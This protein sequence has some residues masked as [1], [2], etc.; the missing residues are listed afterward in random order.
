[1]L[2]KNSFTHD[3]R[4]LREATSLTEAGYSVTVIALMAK[5]LP[6]FETTPTAINIVRVNRGVGSSL[7]A[8]SD[9]SQTQ[10]RKPARNRRLRNLA[11]RLVKLA[12][13]TPVG[14]IIQK[15]IDH[16]MF[17][18][19]KTTSPDII[20]AHD[21]DTLAVGVRLS[22][23]LGIPLIYDSHEIASQRNH[24]S[25]TRKRRSYDLE[26]KLIDKVDRIIMVSQGCADYTAQIHNIATPDVVMNCPYL[27]IAEPQAR[28]LRTALDIP[29]Q[30]FL[31]VHQGS[32]QRNRGIEQTIEAVRNISDCT[33][34]IIG[35]GQYRPALEQ[36]VVNQRLEDKVK[37]FGPVPSSELVEWTAS[38][39][40]GIAT[41]VGH[42]KSYLHSMPNKLF[43][44]V[45]AGIPVI[46]SNY[47]DMGAFVSENN[48]G[49]TCNPES[50]GEIQQAIE[51]LRDD[52]DLRREFA[53]NSNTARQNF[54]WQK[55]QEKLLA[56][57]RE[58]LNN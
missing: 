54:N 8:V 11:V 7:H 6:E 16:R 48:L 14:E 29:D 36:Y 44:Y 40:L 20:H 39:D 21:L 28:N 1:M 18:A 42:S 2:L 4:V 56:I 27:P 32:L 55:E 58:V 13:A 25:A 26:K 52:A 12:A 45:M 47:P 30:Q 34:V 49:L 17:D 22:K 37:F 10:T 41:I 51:R 24:H 53:T 19:A 46:A 3:A 5:N 15:K 23:E 33:L 38:A 35:F 43:E 57:Y 31:V 50:V 9:P